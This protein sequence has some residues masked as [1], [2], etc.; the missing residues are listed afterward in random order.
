MLIKNVTVVG[1]DELLPQQ[2]VLCRDGKIVRIAPTSDLQD[3]TDPQVI[4][5]SDRYLAPGYIDLHIHGAGD[6]LTDNG[7]DDLA[8]LSKLLPKYGVTGFLPTICPH[9][10]RDDSEFIASLAAVP[11]PGAQNLGFHQEGLFLALA[12]AINVDA[13]RTTGVDTIT[14]IIDAA[15]PYPVIFSTSPEYQNITELIPIM[16]RNNTPVFMTHTQAD[17]K[18]SLAAIEAGMRHATH[19]YDVFHVPPETEPGVRPCG[20]VEAVLADPRV[21][22]DFILDGVHVDPI[23]VKMALACKGPDRVCLITDANIGAGSPPG[24]YMSPF[25]GEIEFAYPGAPARM[26]EN[27]DRP[28]CLAGSG[29]TMDRAVRNATEMLS[30]DLPLAVRMATANPA[31]VL[32]RAAAKGQ[33]KEGFDADMVLLDQQLEVQQCWVAGNSCF[34]S[35]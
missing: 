2:S 18:Q 21:S 31:K 15:K 1:L 24:R 8:A 16:A 28:G 27:T 29:L 7:P 11:S 3:T 4:D 35:H 20:A 10:D 9:P 6:Y 30:V 23:A 22:V 13:M 12:G 17:V 32:G 26:T 34:T 33:I 25:C 5:G 19:F 14:A